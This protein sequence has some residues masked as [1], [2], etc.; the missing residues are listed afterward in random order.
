MLLGGKTQNA[1]SSAP[2]FKTNNLT[3]AQ[4]AAAGHHFPL[5]GRSQP[6]GAGTESEREM[7][8]AVFLLANLSWLM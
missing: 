6:P 2:T 8:I 3:S 1:G 5:I 4:R 7:E